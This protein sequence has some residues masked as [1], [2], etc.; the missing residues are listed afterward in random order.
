MT[1]AREREEAIKVLQPIIEAI[2]NNL[3]DPTTINK[4]C[5]FALQSEPAPL[6]SSAAIEQADIEAAALERAAKVAEARGQRLVLTHSS[7][8]TRLNAEG[9][10]LA[11]AIRALKPEPSHDK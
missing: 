2:A 6:P 7:G 4:I 10:T 1:S 5:A 8:S 3:V 9:E 11:A